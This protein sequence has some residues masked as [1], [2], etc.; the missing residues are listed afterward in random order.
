MLTL[1]T[2]LMRTTKAGLTVSDYMTKIKGVVDDLTLIGHPMSNEELISHTLNG[3]QDEFKELTAAVRVRD[4]TI[5]FEDLYDKL[6]DEEMI[7]QRSEPK[8]PEVSITAQFTH[9][10]SGHK[11]KGGHYRPF[12]HNNKFSH[13]SS[14]K[15]SQS[16]SFLP[17]GN[18][19]PSG[20][21]SPS[22][23]SWR[24]NTQ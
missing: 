8:K 5:S 1:L 23:N 11:P 21:F 16:Y 6:L 9:K 3:L 10:G 7:Q 20:P 2:S 19:H 14:P 12:P 24:P 17:P 15:Q 13:L 18:S 22:T 4:S